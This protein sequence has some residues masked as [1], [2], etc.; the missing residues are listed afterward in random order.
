MVKYENDS[1]IAYRWNGGVG[2]ND[3]IT[4]EAVAICQFM[5]VEIFSIQYDGELHIE[6]TFGL[7][8]IKNGDWIT[9][10]KNGNI[11]RLS[12]EDFEKKYSTIK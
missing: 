9:K 4:R 5:D 3:G 11:G 1:I 12:N 6:L 7:L 2:I 8:K 10:D